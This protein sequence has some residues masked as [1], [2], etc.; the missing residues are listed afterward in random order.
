MPKFQQAKNVSEFPEVKVAEDKLRD[1]MD[2]RNAARA[3][4]SEL[5]ALHA[6][7]RTTNIESEAARLIATG[8][9]M[10]VAERRV[11]GDDVAT[12]AHKLQVL[13]AA[14]SMQQQEVDKVRGRISRAAIEPMRG[15]YT[16]KLQAVADALENLGAAVKDE[17]DYI[18]R[19]DAAGYETG[20]LNLAGLS[21]AFNPGMRDD[22]EGSTLRNFIET[23]KANGHD[24]R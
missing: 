4:H 16:A 8:T 3:E 23:A 6:A 24:I 22:Q 21:P 15:E 1:L 5:A 20:A 9:A 7:V 14:V 12:A 10:V 18:R 2:Q 17:R 19:L 11:S 13:D